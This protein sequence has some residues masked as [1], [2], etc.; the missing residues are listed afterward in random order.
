MRAGGYIYQAVDAEPFFCL[1]LQP[2]GKK[3]TLGMQEDF[4]SVIVYK[5]RYMAKLCC[6]LIGHG[7]DFMEKLSPRL[8]SDVLVV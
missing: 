3:V 5:S 4:K 1:M 6:R 2:L 8:F 7:F